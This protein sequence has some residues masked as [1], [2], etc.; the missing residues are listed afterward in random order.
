MVIIRGKARIDL[1]GNNGTEMAEESD[2]DVLQ[3]WLAALAAA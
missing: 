1:A 3:L 2:D